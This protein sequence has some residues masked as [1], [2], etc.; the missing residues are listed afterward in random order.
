M[1]GMPAGG[2]PPAGYFSLSLEG[3]VFA[4]VRVQQGF[5]TGTAAPAA[6]TARGERKRTVLATI[7]KEVP[8]VPSW[9]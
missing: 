4:P 5:G 6:L 9:R 8:V 1:G 3:D 2:W 7:S